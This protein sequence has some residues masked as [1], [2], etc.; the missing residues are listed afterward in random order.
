MPS[1]ISVGRCVSDEGNARA[2]VIA[3]AT[4][5][6]QRPKRPAH[7]LLQN[8]VST[9]RRRC[10]STNEHALAYMP[11]LSPW[12]S[13][14]TDGEPKTNGNIVMASPAEIKPPRATAFSP[15]SSHVG[16]K[17]CPATR[18]SEEHTS[19]L[20]SQSNLVCRLLLEKKKNIPT[21]YVT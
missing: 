11:R 18:R 20:Q 3:R 14:D 9:S 1:A 16:P 15:R 4:L 6:S 5:N 8:S 13:I 12:S 7:S 21:I 10:R 17:R 19:E 2:G